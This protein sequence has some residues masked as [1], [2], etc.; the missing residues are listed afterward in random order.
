MQKILAQGRVDPNS[1][2]YLLVRLTDRHAIL[3]SMAKLREVYAN[4]LHLEKPG[5]L[6]TGDKTMNREALKRGELEM[7]RDFFKQITGQELDAE[8]DAAI[9]ETVSDIRKSEDNAL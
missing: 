1:D 2:D 5:M 4:V 9:A 8:Q 7:F 6:E 3:D